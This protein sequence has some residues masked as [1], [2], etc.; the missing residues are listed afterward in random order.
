MIH[1]RTFL[2]LVAGFVLVGSPAMAVEEPS[3]VV[4]V[5]EPGFEVRDYPALIAAQVEA[6]GRD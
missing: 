6:S 1:R 4:S 3:F 5:R 2:A